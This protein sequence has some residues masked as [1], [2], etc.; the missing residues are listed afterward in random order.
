MESLL[1]A[2]ALFVA[3]VAEVSTEQHANQEAQ[4]AAASDADLAAKLRNLA[5]KGKV[6]YPAMML[7][8]EDAAVWSRCL[9]AAAAAIASMRESARALGGTPAESVASASVQRTANISVFF[10][11]APFAHILLRQ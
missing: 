2:E 4:T 5:T 1:R 8:P 7:S 9:F 6:R 3:R 10:V 11:L